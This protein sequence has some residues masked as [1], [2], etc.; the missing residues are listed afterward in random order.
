[1]TLLEGLFLFGEMLTVPMAINLSC[2]I[3]GFLLF[4][5]SGLISAKKN[6]VHVAWEGQVDK[7]NGGV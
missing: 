2:A 1:M 4:L 3:I 7:P 6:S 5:I